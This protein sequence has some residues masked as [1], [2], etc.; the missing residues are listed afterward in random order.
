MRI[1]KKT[2]VLAAI[3]ATTVGGY[4][5]YKAYN[6][7]I[8]STMFMQNVEA[9]SRDESGSKIKCYT[10]FVYEEGSSVV[11]CTTCKRYENHSDAWYNIHDYCITSQ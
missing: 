11:D 2:I 7:P 9:L 1:L 5:G 3:A 4:Q 10:S 6:K 8:E